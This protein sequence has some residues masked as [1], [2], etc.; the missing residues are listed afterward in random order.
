MYSPNISLQCYNLLISSRLLE[1]YLGRSIEKYNSFLN[2]YFSLLL[3]YFIYCFEWGLISLHKNL[4]F[5][6]WEPEHQSTARVPRSNLDTKLYYL[7][8]YWRLCWSL[9]LLPRRSSLKMYVYMS[10][11]TLDQLS[12]HKSDIQ[13]AIFISW[14]DIKLVCN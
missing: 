3:L 4:A 1:K 7:I 10:P 12:F 11:S 8:N 14:I 13:N 9:R 6:F 2:T 5:Y